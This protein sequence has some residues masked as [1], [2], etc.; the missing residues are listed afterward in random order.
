MTLKQWVMKTFKDSNKQILSIPELTDLLWALSNN[1]KKLKFYN[2]LLKTVEQGHVKEA[3]GELRNRIYT[4]NKSWNEFFV[5]KSI[6]PHLIS[7]KDT[8]YNKGFHLSFQLYFSNIN[9]FI[10]HWSKKYIDSM[11]YKYDNNINKPLTLKSRLAL[12]EWKNGSKISNAKLASI[13][14]NYPLNFIDDK[15]KRYLNDKED[16]GAIWNIFYI[17]CLAPNKYPIFDQHTYRAMIYLKCGEI[18]EISNKDK[19]KYNIYLNEY[20][21]FIASLNGIPHRKL[22]KAL[23][24]CGQFL[25]IAKKYI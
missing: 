4:Q 9:D 25:K 3:K 8:Q 14:K 10:N 23:F 17:H 6:S 12:F 15:E 2:T 19:D 16:G 20:I 13:E 5:D 22:D 24:A 18:V 11:E 21:P 1:G 7:L